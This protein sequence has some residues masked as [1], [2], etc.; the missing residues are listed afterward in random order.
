MTTT[1]WI[2]TQLVAGKTVRSEAGV[3][4]KPHTKST[5]H[6]VYRVVC[7]KGGKYDFGSPA[8][9]ARFAVDGIAAG[10]R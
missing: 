3:V 2:E 5:G 9:A 10:S 1:R 4:A 8:D 6:A 7:P